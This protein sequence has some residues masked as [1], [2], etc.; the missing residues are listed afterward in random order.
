MVITAKIPVS[1]MARQLEGELTWLQE[2]VERVNPWSFSP[3]LLVAFCGFRPVYRFS[4]F[5]FVTAVSKGKVCRTGS[6]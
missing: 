6:L 4:H 5:G 1:R 2:N 3:S